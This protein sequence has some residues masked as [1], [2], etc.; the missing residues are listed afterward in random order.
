MGWLILAKVS[1]A[2]DPNYAALLTTWPSLVTV[3]KQH[4]QDIWILIQFKSNKPGN[5]ALVILIL[6][7]IV[8][9]SVLVG[10][11]LLKNRMFWLFFGSAAG[12][13][14]LVCASNWNAIMDR[15]LHHFTP[16]YF[17]LAL[18]FLVGWAEV[19]NQALKGVM[20]LVLAIAHA[21]ASIWFITT[22]SL[23]VP[24]RISMAQ[25]KR[26]IAEIEQ[27]N[28]DQTV[29]LVGSYWNTYAVDALS[30]QII[31]I[32]GS[33][34]LVRTSRYKEQVFGCTEIVVIKTN[35]REDLTEGLEQHGY[36]LLKSSADMNL[37]DFV[38]AYYRVIDIEN[39]A[40]TPN[41]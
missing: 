25:A 14:L 34:E 33:G 13:Y 8:S 32:P 29:G 28:P 38:Y 17:F 21:V 11:R 10:K 26:L 5:S 31:S 15:P 4:L 30:D 18:A 41:L 36:L 9:L 6:L 19:K 39:G 3:L 37:D 27:R 7:N 24:G 2:S 20:P 22:L 23:T 35:W 40:K 16:A 12:T 1:A